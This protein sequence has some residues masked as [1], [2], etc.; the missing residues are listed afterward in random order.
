MAFTLYFLSVL[1][2]Y[3]VCAKEEE[4]TTDFS[5]VE[6]T[7][8]LSYSC[9]GLGLQNI[10]ESIPHA[11]E[12]LD[13]SF[14]Y[15]NALY[16]L[17][18]KN[19]PN[20]RKVDL[21]RCN[22]NWIYEHAFINNIH[23]HTI[24]LIG[25]PIIFIS[26]MA[27]DGPISLRHLFLQQTSISNLFFVPMSNLEDL[28]TLNLGN[29]FISSLWFP[30]D[31]PTKNLKT[32]DFQSNQIKKIYARDIEVLNQVNDLNLILK[33]NN[34]DYIEPNSFNSSKLQILDLLGSA[35]NVD[36]SVLLN[37]LNGLSTTVLRVG[38]F[39]DSKH[40]ELNPT[41][42]HSLCSISMKE[43]N[44][45]FQRFYDL[46]ATNFSCIKNITKLDLTGTDI[47]TLPSFK[48]DNI[49]SELVLSRNKFEQICDIQADNFHHLTHLT[50][51]ENTEFLNLGDGCLE[52]LSKLQYLDLSY[53]NIGSTTC[54]RGQLKGLHNLKHLNFS[55][56][57][58]Q[59]FSNVTFQD[60]GN[61]EV[62][63]L[64]YT[65]IFFTES[66][67]PFSNLKLL[68]VM[69]LSM[70]RINDSNVLIFEGLKNLV[71]LNMK[72]SSFQSGMI[73]NN[74]VFQYTLNLEV[75]ILS[76]CDLTAIEER[77][78][79]KLEK[80]NY[81]D[82]SYNK[83][84]VFSSDAFKDLHQIYLNYAFNLIKII[85]LDLVRTISNKSVINLSHNPLDCSCSNIQFITWYKENTRVFEDIKYTVCGSPVSTVGKEVCRLTI[86]CTLSSLKI[87]F[88]IMGIVVVIAFVL[89]VIRYYKKHQYDGL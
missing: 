48:T 62:L 69:N 70:S 35:V 67:G 83:L 59:F 79:H 85:P 44:L 74:N 18:F 89:L 16:K 12:I 61:L 36:P 42:F 86:S 55:Y 46:S 57:L 65:R 29:N 6:I 39:Q 19:L 23:L 53:S 9:E 30:E 25:N 80:L 73:K 82:L 26:D 63:D 33:T 13:F 51:R 75:L 15:L 88:I 7:A 54:C 77:A 14:N 22:I 21:T 50:L 38:T 68:K 81:V 28:E 31:F 32:L 4:S 52:N 40:F 24:L 58:N 56:N 8:N 27:F 1:L 47:K 17:T 78:F 49:L 11:T 2:F 84:A 76:S 60:N 43:L 71:Y 20:L 45:Q 72:S 3:P 5:C 41:F 10:P 37:G 87:F 66:L 64:A 34:M